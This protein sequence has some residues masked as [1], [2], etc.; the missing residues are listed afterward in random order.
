MERGGGGGGWSGGE[1]WSLKPGASEVGG[2]ISVT[3]ARAGMRGTWK[4]LSLARC[5]YCIVTLF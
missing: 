4:P 5:K 3:G 2:C 1:D